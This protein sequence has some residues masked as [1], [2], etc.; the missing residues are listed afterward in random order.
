MAKI[1]LCAVFALACISS[2]FAATDKKDGFEIKNNQVLITANG[3]TRV[4]ADNMKLHS[5]IV[6]RTD[7]TVVVP[8]GDRATLKEGDTMS[9]GGTIT[10]AASGKVEQLTPVE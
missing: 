6:V 10:R 4:M 9:F 1:F 5:G 8:G 2:S 3:T 7:G